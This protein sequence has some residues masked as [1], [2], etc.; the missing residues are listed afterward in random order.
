MTPEHD[1]QHDDSTI[2]AF[3]DL[4]Q[5]LTDNEKRSKA[6][7]EELQQQ[8]KKTDERLDIVVDELQTCTLLILR[9]KRTLAEFV[10]EHY[11]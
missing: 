8:M 4:I 3:T 5:K 11:E 2:S 6:K 7:I 1:T 9:L 10:E